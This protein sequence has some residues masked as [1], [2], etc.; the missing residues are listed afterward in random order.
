VFT[1]ITIVP[2][3]THFYA[4]LPFH[5]QLLFD[6]IWMIIA[7]LLPIA[8]IVAVVKAT[9]LR[10]SAENRRHL[11]HPV[12]GWGAAL[13]AAFLNALFYRVIADTLR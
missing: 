5:R 4:S 13:A 1:A 3:T 6:E 12:V 2:M 7:A 9:A 11:W 10:F 8:T